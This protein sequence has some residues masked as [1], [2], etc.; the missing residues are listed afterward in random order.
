MPFK[1]NSFDC[2]IILTVP[3]HTE[4]QKDIIL[5]SMG[6]TKKRII[7]LED[8]YTNIIEKIIINV[9]D[10]IINLEL[11]HPH[12]NRANPEWRIF[13]KAHGLK[14][15]TVRFPR[16]YLVFKPVLYELEKI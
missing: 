1:D 14:I 7:V 15:I 12:L 3:H 16:R 9:V 11:R 6:V 4:Y 8:I 13:F 2:S 10:S 5:D